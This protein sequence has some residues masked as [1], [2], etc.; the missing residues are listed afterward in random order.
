MDKHLEIL[1]KSLKTR[2]ADS[3]FKIIEE[4]LD[5]IKFVQ[6]QLAFSR[7]REQQLE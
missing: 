1:N 7:R 3:L 4:A 6:A 2:D 5:H